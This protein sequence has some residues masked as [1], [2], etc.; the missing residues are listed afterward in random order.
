MKWILLPVLAFLLP[1]MYVGA[2]LHA[3][4]EAGPTGRLDREKWE[5]LTRDLDYPVS[6]APQEE[7]EVYDPGA[8][9]NWTTFFKVVAVVSAIAIL[10]FIVHQLMSGES[11]FGPKNRKFSNGLKI[12]L[13]HIEANLP[14]ADIPDFIRDALQAGDYKM[15]VRLH[16][17]GLIQLLAHKEW[18]AWKRDKTNGDYLNEMRNRPVF[19]G[20]QEATLVFE[21]IW[22]G[23]RRL[24]Q[25]GYQQIAGSFS[26]LEQVI[27]TS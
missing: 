21:R 17:L 18:V 25:K 12:N 7:E 4:A 11:L 27:K 2:E 19:D 15:A 23:D 3:Q 9:R 13:E 1:A 6:G 20:F 14:E 22:Y 16:Y 24:G 5:A 26:A 10:A 8:T